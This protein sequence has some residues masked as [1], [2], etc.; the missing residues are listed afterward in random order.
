MRSI[1]TQIIEFVGHK[2]TGNTYSIHYCNTQR[3]HTWYIQITDTEI[4]VTISV[5]CD[6]NLRPFY[7]HILHKM[8]FKLLDSFKTNKTV[9]TWPLEQWT[10]IYTQIYWLPVNKYLYFSVKMPIL[11]VE[12]PLYH[13]GGH[14]YHIISNIILGLQPILRFGYI[15]EIW[16]YTEE[17]F[18]HWSDLDVCWWKL[19]HVGYGQAIK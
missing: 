8:G 12:F 7:T 6:L 18:I 1:S 2:H 5:R 10:Q 4:S 15:Q 13:S 9:P 19:N 16:V 3:S 17:W 11:S 14:G